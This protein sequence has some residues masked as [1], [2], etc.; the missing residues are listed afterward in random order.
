[1]Q[2]VLR[3]E[4]GAAALCET[5]SAPPNLG[6][7]GEDCPLCQELTGR[8]ILA[9]LDA[10][11]IAIVDLPI[12]VTCGLMFVPS[13]ECAAEGGGGPVLELFCDERDREAGFAGNSP[14]A[15]GM[16]PVWETLGEVFPIDLFAEVLGGVAHHPFPCANLLDARLA[17]TQLA[18][19]E[20]EVIR[21]VLAGDIVPVLDHPLQDVLDDGTTLHEQ[22]EV[23]VRRSP[24]LWFKLP[25]ERHAPMPT[26]SLFEELEEPLCFCRRHF[27]L[28]HRQGP[29]EDLIWDHSG[30]VEGIE[31]REQL[32]SRS[33]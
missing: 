27:S 12:N 17:P 32:S 28:G 19:V 8:D 7:A 26:P 30:A 14:P 4:H 29:K 5:P 20:L 1:M 31:D 3:N 6:P 16:L 18:E 25:D 15:A 11:S 22:E 33:R 10:L 21:I 24:L 13:D 23:E 2:H 9:D